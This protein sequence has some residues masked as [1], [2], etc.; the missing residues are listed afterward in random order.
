MSV[1]ETV[2]AVPHLLTLDEAAAY[3]RTPIGTLR[4]WRYLDIGPQG[5]RVGRRVMF[6]RNDLERWLTEQHDAES[7]RR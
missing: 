3:L 2:P 1:D 7:V 5:F 4:Y 6:G